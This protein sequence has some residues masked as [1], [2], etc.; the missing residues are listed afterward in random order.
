MTR[1]ALAAIGG[2]GLAY[3]ML[4]SA[5]SAAEHRDVVDLGI[6]HQVIE[7]FGASD[8]W[9]MQAAGQWSDANRQR[10]ADLLFSQEKGIGLSLWR[11]NIGAGKEPG[12]HNIPDPF[13]SAEC[14]EVSPG[15]YDWSRQAGQQ[16]FLKAAKDRG[17]DQFLAFIN[18]PPARMTRTGLTNSADDHTSPT[19]LKA[20]YEGEFARFLTDVLVHFRDVGV[21]PAITEGDPVKIDFRFVSP[22]NEPNVDWNGTKQEGNRMDNLTIRNTVRALHAEMTRRGVK[23]EI[24]APESTNISDMIRPASRPTTRFASAKGDYIDDLIGDH[25]IAPLL[26]HRICYH[27]Y[28]SWREPG[29]LRA[30]EQIRDKMKQYPGWRSWMSEICIMDHKRDLG[31][32]PALLLGRMI[33]QGLAVAGN[34]AWHWWLALSVYDYKDGLLYTDWRKPGDTENV[35]DSKM[36]WAMG[37]YSRFIR[38]G[39]VRVELTG[40]NHSHEGLLGSAYL[41]PN[42]S[43][44]VVVYVNSGGNNETV[45][46]TFRSPMSS[47]PYAPTRATAWITSDTHS[48]QRHPEVEWGKPL[49]IPARSIMT[50]VLDP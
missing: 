21:S 25:S 41:D 32:D 13:R 43:K 33:H 16:W 37:N 7:N 15:V 49:T 29:L 39:F 31:M 23:S 22:I 1:T 36:L 48:L 11:F 5:A 19:N 40:D 8:A 12:Q 20:G 28:D 2:I 34:S 46:L 6:R 14:F 18:S 45:Q 26:S 35:L 42:S 3:G 17:V 9:T 30:S 4:G 10:I 27:I 47:T 44:V 24:L 38:P 50:L